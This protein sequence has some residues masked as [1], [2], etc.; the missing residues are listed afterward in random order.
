[1]VAPCGD[2]P[3]ARPFFYGPALPMGVL[4]GPAPPFANRQFNMMREG[5]GYG[6]ADFDGSL[7]PVLR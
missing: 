2:L 6:Q 7:V 1:M 4:V 5:H 3:G